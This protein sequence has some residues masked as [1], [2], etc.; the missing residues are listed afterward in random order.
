M[1]N[2]EAYMELFLHG[3]NWRT[4]ASTVTACNIPALA[5]QVTAGVL[6]IVGDPNVV[7]MYSVFSFLFGDTA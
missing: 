5:Q 4:D 1:K 3:S 7:F 2:V 6:Q